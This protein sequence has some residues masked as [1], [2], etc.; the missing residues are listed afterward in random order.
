MKVEQIKSLIA[1]GEGY[2]AEFKVS[3]PSKVRELTEEICAFA[4]SAGGFLIIGVNDANEIKVEITNPGGLLA[5]VG[6]DFGHKSLSRNPLIFGL[7]QRMRLVERIGSGIPRMEELMIASNLPVPIYKTEGMFTV[8]FNRPINVRASSSIDKEKTMEK[9]VE[10]IM[11]KTVEE[12]VEEKIL[13]L[14]KQ[15]PSITAKEIQQETLLSRRGV[16][17][18]LNKLKAAKII[19]RI[20]PNKGGQW[21]I[22]Q[23]I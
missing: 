3:V 5:A 22:V 14:I 23:N 21:S 7:F 8:I 17:Y 12:T 10:E 16:E 2:Q 18:Q 11:E 19:T 20:G 1:L 4:N 9:T 13:S 15:K 6:K